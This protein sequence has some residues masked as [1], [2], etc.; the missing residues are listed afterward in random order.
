ML[1]IEKY[2]SE[3]NIFIG[4]ELVE[5]SANRLIFK[6]RKP[7]LPYI[8][9]QENIASIYYI[10]STSMVLLRSSMRYSSIVGPFRSKNAA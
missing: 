4:M 1:N 6:V 8:K 5:F 3:Y 2:R 10:E 7:K 9:Y